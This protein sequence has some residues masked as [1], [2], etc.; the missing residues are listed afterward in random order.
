MPTL[1]GPLAS[2]TARMLNVN[3]LYALLVVSRSQ[4]KC[5]RIAN[6]HGLTMSEQ[7]AHNRLSIVKVFVASDLFVGWRR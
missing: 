2:E 5:K 4:P 6:F 3:R 1:L 7:N